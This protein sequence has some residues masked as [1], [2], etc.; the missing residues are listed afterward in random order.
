MNSSVLLAG[1]LDDL[2]TGWLDMLGRWADKGLPVAL[3]W[4]VITELVRRGSLKA[5]IG[6]LLAMA[7]ALGIY[8]SKFSLASI[9]ED[10]VKNPAKSSPAVVRVV[11][12][13]PPAG[14]SG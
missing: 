6:A 10:E 14:G 4:I 5:G 9:F 13:V 1:K 12:Q 11:D 7:I 2:G 3:S 8:A